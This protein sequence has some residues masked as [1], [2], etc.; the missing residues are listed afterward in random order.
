[1]SGAGV[2]AVDLEIVGVTGDGKALVRDCLFL[3]FAVEVAATHPM[4]LKRQRFLHVRI[5]EVSCGVDDDVERDILAVLRPD[6]PGR[7]AFDPADID[8]DIVAGQ[9]GQIVVGR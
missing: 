6:A 4:H 3:P 2:R 8:I 1:M 9:R 7:D 5:G